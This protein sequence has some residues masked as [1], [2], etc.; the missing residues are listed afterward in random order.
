M[1]S[2]CRKAFRKLA[3]KA[4]ESS[5]ADHQSATIRVRFLD[6]MSVVRSFFA[7]PFVDV[8]C[9]LPNHQQTALCVAVIMDREARGRDI[10]IGDVR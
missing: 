9:S 3:E 6:V 1:F 7:S 5:D 2:L 4:A 8:V 10:A